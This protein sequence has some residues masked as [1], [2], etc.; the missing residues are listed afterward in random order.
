MIFSDMWHFSNTISYFSVKFLCFS[1]VFMKRFYVFLSKQEHFWNVHTF[2]KIGKLKKILQADPNKILSGFFIIY[3]SFPSSD[4][5]VLSFFTAQKMKFSI[6]DFFSK[7]DQIRSFLQIWSH[8]LKKSLMKN[9][10]F[11]S[12]VCGKRLIF[13]YL[14]H[15]KVI[16]LSRKFRQT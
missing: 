9:F 6:K 3:L 16:N 5:D 14:Q 10:I 11:L 7:F 2:L 1:A 4:F 15:K 12:S 13:H 8:L